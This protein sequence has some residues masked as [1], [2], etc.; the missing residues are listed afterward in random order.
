MWSGSS[1]Q[2]WKMHMEEQAIPQQPMGTVW[3][4]SSGA[5]VEEPVGQHWMVIEGAEP[6]P[7]RRPCGISLGKTAFHVKDLMRRRD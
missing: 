6:E 7:L 5:V 3:N 4:R 2:P 1:L